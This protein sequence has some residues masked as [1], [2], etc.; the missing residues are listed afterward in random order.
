MTLRVA[1]WA[2]VIFAMV[3]GYLPQCSA[4]RAM[5]LRGPLRR[6]HGVVPPPCDPW[7]TV[8]PVGMNPLPPCKSPLGGPKPLPQPVPLPGA[9]HDTTTINVYKGPAVGVGP[10]VTGDIASSVG[11]SA[12]SATRPASGVGGGS[13]LVGSALGAFAQAVAGNLG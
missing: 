10:I 6:L 5:A 8:L 13:D 2:M 4:G 3:L 7:K 9:Q 11:L 1:F 12:N